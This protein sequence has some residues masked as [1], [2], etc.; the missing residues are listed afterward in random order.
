M[1]QALLPILVS[2][3]LLVSRESLGARLPDFDGPGESGLSLQLRLAPWGEEGDPRE[4]PLAA[5]SSLPLLRSPIRGSPA[6]GEPR[7]RL[8]K[9]KRNQ[10]PLSIDLTFHLLRLVLAEARAQRQQEQAEEN[11]HLFDSLGK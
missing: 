8:P 11:R 1:R 7:R 10:P 6:G 5:P 3:L 4:W 9:L 2:S